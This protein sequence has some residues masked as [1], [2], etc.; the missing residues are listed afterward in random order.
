M[1]TNFVQPCV[2]ATCCA[3]AN[4]QAYM[5]LAPMYRTLPARRPPRREPTDDRSRCRSS[6]F[7]GTRA[8]RADPR[9]PVGPDPCLEHRTRGLQS[10]SVDG[11]IVRLPKQVG[12]DFAVFVNGVAQRE[13]VD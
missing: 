7:P 13:G 5:L 1:E 6:S 12:G 9:R 10:P 8:R 11:S 3:R 4:C 2:S